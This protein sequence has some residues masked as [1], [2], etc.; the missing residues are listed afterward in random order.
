MNESQYNQLNTAYEQARARFNQGQQAESPAGVRAQ[1]RQSLQAQRLQ[2]QSGQNQARA[3]R[4]QRQSNLRARGQFEQ[5]QRQRLQNQPQTRQGQGQN[6]Q[7]PTGT[8]QDRDQN[9]QDQVLQN[10]GIR[11][12]T[13]LTDAQLLQM[14]SAFEEDFGRAV[15]TTLT[16]AQKR[17]R[18]NQLQMQFRGFGAFNN[19]QVQ[20]ELNLTPQQQQQFGQLARDWRQDLAQLNRLYAQDPQAATS[21]FNRLQQQFENQLGT[22]LSAQQLQAWR[23]IVGEPFRFNPT[24]FLGTSTAQARTSARL[25]PTGDR[26]RAEVNERLRAQQSDRSE[27]GFDIDNSLDVG[28]EGSDIDVGAPGSDLDVGGASGTDDGVQLD[29]GDDLDGDNQDDTNRG[30]DAD[31]SVDDSAAR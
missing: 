22:V 24:L 8:L 3:L 30:T 11:D 16:D 27:T 31:R 20:Q 18:F 25:D 19:P 29:V 2:G 23:D 12:S 5:G 6:L 15:D 17:Q 10:Q 7:D 4:D 1:Q 21:Q 26:T 14:Q 28:R 9:L 13:G